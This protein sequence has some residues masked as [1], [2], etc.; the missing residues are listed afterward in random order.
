MCSASVPPFTQ[1]TMSILL[2]S[3]FVFV[4]FG[5]ILYHFSSSSIYMPH[6]SS[7]HI[8]RDCQ[9]D[10]THMCSAFIHRKITIIMIQPHKRRKRRREKTKQ[11][12]HNSFVF[13]SFQIL[14]ILFT[15]STHIA[16][17]SLWMLVK[18]FVS[19]HISAHDSL[20]TLGVHYIVQLSSVTRW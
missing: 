17:S 12:L 13:F 1:S 11:N 3:F 4:H 7:L 5:V 15:Y 9:C 19:F 6:V 2:D 14:F 16:L 8:H 18:V 20:Y 10:T